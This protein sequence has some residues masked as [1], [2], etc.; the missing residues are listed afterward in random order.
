LVRLAGGI[1]NIKL[2]DRQPAIHFKT[3]VACP[4]VSKSAKLAENGGHF[5]NRL[6]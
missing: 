5:A 1:L 6:Y 2:P 3:A 4:H